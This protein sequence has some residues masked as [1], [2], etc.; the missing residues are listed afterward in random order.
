MRKCSILI[1]DSLTLMLS[2]CA[3]IAGAFGIASE[4]YVDEQ[5]AAIRDE[6]SDELS[7]AQRSV[8]EA[9][10]ASNENKTAIMMSLREQPTSSMS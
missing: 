9:V 7:S 2:G 3:S 6:V 5:A 1:V 8:T 10:A 4:A